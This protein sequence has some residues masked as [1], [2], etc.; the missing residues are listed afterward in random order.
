MTFFIPAWN[1]KDFKD[2]LLAFRFVYPWD[3][4]DDENG[5]AEIKL[6]HSRSMPINIIF[7]LHEGGQSFADRYKH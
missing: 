2:I 3:G 5:N 6:E 1:N 7:F 4:S